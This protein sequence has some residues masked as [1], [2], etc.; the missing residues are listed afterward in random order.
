MHDAAGY[1][2][3][4]HR[5]RTKLTP[6]TESEFV[7]VLTGVSKFDELCRL[8]REIDRAT[9]GFVTKTELDDIIKVLY[10]E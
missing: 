4:M 1:T 10:E 7:S 6:I 2:G 9:T 8:L 5:G 3:Q